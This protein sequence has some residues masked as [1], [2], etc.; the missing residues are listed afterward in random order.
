MRNRI[1]GRSSQIEGLQKVGF[2]EDKDHLNA[3]SALIGRSSWL[4]TSTC[5]ELKVVQALMIE[6]CLQFYHATEA[7][8]PCP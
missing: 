8:F 7:V 2:F 5:V 4:K 1:A 6:L 3:R